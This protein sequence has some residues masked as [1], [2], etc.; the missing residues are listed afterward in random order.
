MTTATTVIAATTLSTTIILVDAC[1]VLDMRSTTAFAQNAL[2]SF[3]GV[4]FVEMKI[5]P[6]CVYNVKF[7]QTHPSQTHA[8]VPINTTKIRI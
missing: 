3:L 8:P 2:T 6:S 1:V 4:L 7:P 5:F